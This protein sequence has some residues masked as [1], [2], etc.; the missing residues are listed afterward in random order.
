MKPHVICHMI[1]SLDGRIHPS[2]WTSSPDGASKA[3]SE[4]YEAIHEEFGADAWLVGRVTMAEMTKAKANPPG[5]GTQPPRPRHIARRDAGSYAVTIDR[6][7][8]LQFDKPDIGGDHVVVLLGRD[9]PDS[10]LAG[11]VA[12]G[13]S[14]ILAEDEA[15]SIDPLLEVLE[16][17]FGIRTLLLE[18]GGATN[19]RLMAAGLVDEISLLIAP[20]IDGADGVEGVFDAGER[21]AGKAELSLLSTATRPHGLVHLRYAVAR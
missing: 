15:M 12:A 9:V 3:W 8:K 13:V 6:S 16:R 4:V 2:R 1:V 17:D 11:L 14:Y 20:A 10:H 18:G 21:L 5:A 7:G 19:G